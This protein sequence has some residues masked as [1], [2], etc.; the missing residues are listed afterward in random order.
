MATTATILNVS[1]L[2]ELE[3]K[4]LKVVCDR[5]ARTI[6]TIVRDEEGIKLEGYRERGVPAFNRGAYA[7]GPRQDFFTGH[8]RLM[9]LD[10]VAWSTPYW[11]HYTD[12]PEMAK[13]GDWSA[14][15]DTSDER[16]TVFYDEVVKHLQQTEII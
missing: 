4:L 10:L 13:M 11:A 9:V 2:T 5:Q 7:G 16:L 14:V 15:R 8:L 12:Y 3:R 1:I 6:I